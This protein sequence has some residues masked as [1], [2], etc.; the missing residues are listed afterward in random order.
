M[1]RLRFPSLYQQ[2]PLRDPLRFE[3]AHPPP[4][5]MLRG[6]SSTLASSC[7]TS[8]DNYDRPPERQAAIPG[9]VQ[10]LQAAEPDHDDQRRVLQ[11]RFDTRQRPDGGSHN[12]QDC[13]LRPPDRV[14]GPTK[15]MGPRPWQTSARG[16]VKRHALPNVK[17]CDARPESFGCHL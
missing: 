12:R 9:R 4:E 7:S 15:R 17:T 13:P 16:T 11:V 6:G 3:Y 8:W 5:H 1:Q 10:V 2:M 14:R